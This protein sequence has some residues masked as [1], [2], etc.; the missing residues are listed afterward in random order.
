MDYCIVKTYINNGSIQSAAINNGQI[1]YRL[2][3]TD[4]VIAKF[5]GDQC[6]L[7]TSNPIAGII[8]TIDGTLPTLQN[9]ILYEKPIMLEKTNIIKAVAICEGFLNSNTKTFYYDMEK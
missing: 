3:K 2:V 6:I 7:Y 1:L 5:A 9:G 4:D 8:Y